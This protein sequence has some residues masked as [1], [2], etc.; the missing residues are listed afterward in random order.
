MRFF[1]N[2]LN[3]GG[4]YRFL[5]GCGNGKYWLSVG[6]LEIFLENIKICRIVVGL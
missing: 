3:F 2:N 4:V 6:V 5:I 1:F